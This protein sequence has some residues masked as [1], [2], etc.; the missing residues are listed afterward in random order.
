M[1]TASAIPNPLL[2]K[3]AVLSFLPALPLCIIHGVLSH[4]VLPAVGLVPL[5][6]SAGVSLFLL[7]RPR[8]RRRGKQRARGTDVEEAVPSG[9]GE[10]RG[11]EGEGEEAAGPSGLRERETDDDG[12]DGGGEHQSGESVLTHR[13][14]VF[15]VDAGLAAAL[16]VV[17]VFTWIGT[18]RTRE[19]P[20]LAMLAAYATMPLLVN[21]F[22]HLYLAARELVA[23]LAIPSLIEWTAWRAV[24]PNCPHCGSRLRPDALPP[25]PWYDSFSAPN[26]AFPWIKAPSIS[27]PSLP[28]FAVPRFSGLRR[29]WKIPKWMRGRSQESARLFVDD[30]QSERDRYRDDPEEHFGEPSASTTVVATGSADPVPVAEEV[31]VGKKDKKRKSGSPA[32]FEEEASWP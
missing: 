2:R 23:G 28:T 30:E 8:R 15:V 26:V 20:E 16:M 1:S 24:P 19:R 5:S 6:F 4:D 12:S 11:D 27:R 10:E 21:F 17:L 9:G 29:E 25:I 18:G 14:L 22:I 7:V 3:A 13:I 32:M 31:V